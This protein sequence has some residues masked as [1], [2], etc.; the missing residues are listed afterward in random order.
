M[1][2][3]LVKR[4]L[5]KVLEQSGWTMSSVQGAN[6]LSLTAQPAPQGSTLVPTLRTLVSGVQEV[7]RG[8]GEYEVEREGREGGKEV[9][10]ERDSS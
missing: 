9:E 2:K 7:S 6:L 8:E 5:D 3:R 10:K 4:H 1:W